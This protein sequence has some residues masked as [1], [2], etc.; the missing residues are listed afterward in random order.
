MGAN[1]PRRI[2]CGAKYRGRIVRGANCPWGELS[3]IRF[4]DER[5]N[6]NIRVQP[7]FAALRQRNLK[8]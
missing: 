2:A 6:Q 7:I 3:D 8:T 4:E 1:C 5:L